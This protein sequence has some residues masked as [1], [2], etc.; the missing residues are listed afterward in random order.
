MKPFTVTVLDRRACH[1]E[2][3]VGVRDKRRWR[4]FAR[5]MRQQTCE[6]YRVEPHHIYG[7][8]AVW[9]SDRFAAEHGLVAA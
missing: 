7:I 6:G 2:S 3:L 8:P 1:C 5:K 9:V 4:R